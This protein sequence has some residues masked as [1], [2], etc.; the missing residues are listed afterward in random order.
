MS[1]DCKNK[2]K[3]NC[4]AHKN[5][6]VLHKVVSH[7]GTTYTLISAKIERLSTWMVDGGSRFHIVGWETAWKQRREPWIRVGDT[8]ENPCL[9]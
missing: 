6:A 3:R 1:R 9:A 7:G 5:Y 4:K 8:K 2:G